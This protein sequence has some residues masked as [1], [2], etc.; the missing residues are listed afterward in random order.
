MSTL[1]PQPSFWQRE[2][3]L[4]VGQVTTIIGIIT[5][6]GF[7]VSSHATGIAIG[8]ATVVADAALVLVR[9]QVTSP[10]H[11]QQLQQTA[12]EATDAAGNAQGVA[13]MYQLAGTP[14]DDQPP[15][16]GSLVEPVD[17]STGRS[18]SHVDD[19]QPPAETAAKAPAKKAARK[20]VSG[21]RPA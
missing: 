18:R 19:T 1:S 13:A 16:P 5:G 2:P 3:A 15:A 10:A 17:R 11:A 6:A 12:A 20:R 14:E 8:A 7:A 9:R 21:G 4:L